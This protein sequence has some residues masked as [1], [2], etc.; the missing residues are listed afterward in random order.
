MVSGFPHRTEPS[1]KGFVIEDN[2]CGGIRLQ[3]CMR[4]GGP[5]DKAMRDQYAPSVNY[6]DTC[7]GH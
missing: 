2:C 5:L 4:A 1:K 6:D 7:A 3:V